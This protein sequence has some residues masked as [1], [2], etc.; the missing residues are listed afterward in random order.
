M[1]TTYFRE[2]SADNG[3]GG[4]SCRAG[5]GGGPSPQAVRRDADVGD[6]E[7]LEWGVLKEGTEARSPSTPPTY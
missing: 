5:R 2:T 6:V 3:R 1:V 4:G 7:V